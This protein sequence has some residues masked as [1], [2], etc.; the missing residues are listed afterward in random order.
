MNRELLFVFFWSAAFFI[1]I[2]YYAYLSWFN[3]EKFII[4]AEKSNERLYD[5]SSLMN[6]WIHSFWFLFFAK[7]LS[8]IFTV[9]LGFVTVTIM[10]RLLSELV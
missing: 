9:V 1:W 8:L 10:L 6:K 5:N 4:I 2:G 3:S 7:A